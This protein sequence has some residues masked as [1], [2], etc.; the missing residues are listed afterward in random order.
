MLNARNISKL[1]LIY[2]CIFNKYMTVKYKLPKFLSRSFID[3]KFK[4]WCNKTSQWSMIILVSFL[5]IKLNNKE[6]IQLNILKVH[7]FALHEYFPN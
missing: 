5:N 7:C 3:K 4:D 2:L 6:V 1:V